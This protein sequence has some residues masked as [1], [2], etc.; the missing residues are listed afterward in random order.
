MA[1]RSPRFA[2]DIDTSEGREA[3]LGACPDPDIL[4]NNNWGPPP[5][6]W[7]SFDYDDWLSAVESNMLVPIM[8][9]RGVVGGMR[10]R[11]F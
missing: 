8:M 6:D 9:I 4:V 7:V 11:H 2:A 10:R 5:G 1:S 3:L